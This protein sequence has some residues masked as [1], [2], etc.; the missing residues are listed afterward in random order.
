[1]FRRLAHL[2]QTAF[3]SETA[4]ATTEYALVV[5]VTVALLVGISSIVLDGL[6]TQYETVTGVVCW[7]IP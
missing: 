3:R 1:M 6:A 4:Q 5:F 2:A 7:P